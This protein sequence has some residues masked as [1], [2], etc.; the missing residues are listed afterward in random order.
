MLFSISVTLK[1]R[2]S[3]TLSTQMGKEGAFLNNFHFF[4]HHYK[5]FYNYCKRDPLEMPCHL[6]L[7]Q[8][9][10]IF[11]WHSTYI[12]RDVIDTWYARVNQKTRYCFGRLQQYLVYLL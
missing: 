12:C 9:I 3:F 7:D 6:D 1:L 11:S 4:F 8:E 5:C 10:L 2:P